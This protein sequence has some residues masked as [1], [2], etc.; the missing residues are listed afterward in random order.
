MASCAVQGAAALE[1]AQKVKIVV[2][3]K[4]GTLTQGKPAVTDHRLFSSAHKEVDI[5]KSA[6]A[7][8]ASSEHPVA[9]AILDYAHRQICWPPFLDDASTSTSFEGECSDSDLPKPSDPDCTAGCSGWILSLLANH[10]GLLIPNA[11]TW[12]LGNN[13]SSELCSPKKLQDS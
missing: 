6:A 4:T 3:D 2:F 13:I 12:L 8:E 10:Q 1:A 11:D 5:M 9:Q 7:A